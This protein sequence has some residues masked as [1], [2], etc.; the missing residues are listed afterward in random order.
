MTDNTVVT[1][2]NSVIIE[3]NEPHTITFSKS[4]AKALRDKPAQEP[5]PKV[6]AKPVTP[7]AEKPV[8]VAEK[9]NEPGEW[10][11]PDDVVEEPVEVVDTVDV[12]DEPIVL[13][14]T[15][16]EYLKRKAENEIAKARRIERENKQLREQIAKN[17]STPVAPVKEDVVQ[18]ISNI[19]ENIPTNIKS[20]I[21]DEI[22]SVIYSDP[23]MIRLANKESEIKAKQAS[24]K[25]NSHM[26]K[27]NAELISALDDVRD[28]LTEVQQDL[29]FKHYQG[30]IAIQQHIEA[31]QSESYKSEQKIANDY[32]SKLDSVKEKYPAIE[33]ASEKLSKK[34]EQLHIEIRKAIV[35][36]PDAAELTWFI[37]GC[38]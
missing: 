32:Q 19:P 16:P 7:V 30:R 5:L 3:N 2:E 4:E 11:D 31:Q 23:E 28:E 13:K 34:A 26:Y 6:E 1:N 33:K 12:D 27:T 38:K 25:S 36:D 9:T 10:V 35:L 18:P 29:Q 22:D 21:K 15:D 17:Q 24:I 37:C 8:V 14:S 20:R